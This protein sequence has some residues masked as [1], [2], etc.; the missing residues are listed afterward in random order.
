MC[1][2]LTTKLQQLW[3]HMGMLLLGVLLGVIYSNGFDGTFQFDD[4]KVIVNDSRVQS[5]AAWWHSFPQLRPLFKLSVVLNE[6]LGGSLFGFHLFN[7]FI[8]IGNCALLYK[9]SLTLSYSSMKMLP[10]QHFSLMS[11][12]L[13]AMHPAMTEGVTYISG[14]SVA[15][16]AFF[17]LATLLIALRILQTGDTPRTDAIAPAKTAAV[18]TL[19]S[20]AP[21]CALLLCFLLAIATRETAVVLPLFIGLC[22]GLRFSNLCMTRKLL[23]TLLIVSTICLFAV[24]TLA[25]NRVLVSNGLQWPS[26]TSLIAIQ[27][28]SV[29]HL[30]LVAIG[31]APLN[32]DPLLQID[33]L[34]SQHGAIALMVCTAF[35][36]TCWLCWRRLPL[37]SLGLGWAIIA[38][39]PTHSL[40]LR[41]DAVND[42]Q[43]YLAG[44]GLAMAVAALIGS[45]PQ[46]LLRHILVA[47]ATIIIL[48][49]GWATYQRNKAY[50]SELS[51]WQ[52][53]TQ[54]SP[55]NARAWNN[56]GFALACSHDKAGAQQAFEQ[57][58]R[59][60]PKFHQATI[61]L[62]LLERDNLACSVNSA[63][64]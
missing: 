2:P 4:W 15:M 43:L 53:V 28:Q 10:R 6:S 49:S 37:V 48:S 62:Y 39:I 45:R 54:K 47:L 38:W 25:S 50:R 8:H 57:A 35:P 30:L 58:L 3:P 23:V 13:F 63:I 27:T 31:I 59:V 42:R 26:F 40:L 21:G 44:M 16:E 36:F 9:L 64:P 1:F 20:T 41:A 56:V 22:A 7:L 61:N 60:S 19:L 18:T 29:L 14:R 34:W 52:D 5:I 51:Y 12:A 33:P 11:T 24:L 17:I 46:A 55:D 32:G